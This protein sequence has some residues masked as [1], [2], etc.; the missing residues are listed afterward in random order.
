MTL[1][2]TDTLISPQSCDYAWLLCAAGGI[3][4]FR[5]RQP[6][7][8]VDEKESWLWL[9]SRSL[10]PRGMQLIMNEWLFFGGLWNGGG[11]GS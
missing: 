3:F 7:C 10:C 6:S 1:S 4:S 11:V 5:K 2:Q 9:E 8:C